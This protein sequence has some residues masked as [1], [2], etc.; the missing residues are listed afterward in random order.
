MQTIW[1]LAVNTSAHTYLLGLSGKT[2]I[3]GSFA[4]DSMPLSVAHIRYASK[5]LATHRYTRK[6]M[7]DTR[8]DFLDKL[9]GLPWL[10]AGRPM[11]CRKC[12]TGAIG[13]TPL[14]CQHVFCGE[15]VA[16]MDACD[17]CGDVVNK[18][19]P[20]FGLAIPRIVYALHVILLGNEPISE[21]YAINPWD[22]VRV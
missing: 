19:A 14:A 17:V 2:H 20:Q 18:W 12:N 8:D 6:L 13:Y 15:C 16:A 22:D 7:S 21:I 5:F 1:T 11:T 3:L 9:R 10:V 4:V